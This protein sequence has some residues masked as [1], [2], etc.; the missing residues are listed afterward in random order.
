ME[1]MRECYIAKSSFFDSEFANKSFHFRLKPNFI[2]LQEV[3][4]CEVGVVVYI[5]HWQDKIC[6]ISSVA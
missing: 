5:A 1:I 2:G 4:K 6:S 3:L